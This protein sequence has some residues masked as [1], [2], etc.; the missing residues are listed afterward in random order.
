MRQNSKAAFTLIELLVVIAIIAILAAILF[1]VFARARE[2]ARQTSCLSNLKQISLALMMYTQDY[3]EMT[4]QRTSE[5]WAQG[6]G[7]TWRSLIYPYMK[8]AAVLACP[9]NPRNNVIT[10]EDTLAKNGVANLPTSYSGTCTS[11]TKGYMGDELNNPTPWD[12]YGASCTLAMMAAPAQLIAVGEQ[13]YDD[14]GILSLY[15]WDTP[16]TSL[17]LDPTYGVQG[18]TAV[19]NFAFADGHAKAMKPSAT[20]IPVNM[21]AYDNSPFVSFGEQQQILQAADNVIMNQ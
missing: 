8:N 21:W 4:V 5:G 9:S 12:G 6:W 18:H 14:V 7:V 11:F 15:W 3:D 17:Y 13:R 1:P 2:K 20:A 10:W 16:E 19:T